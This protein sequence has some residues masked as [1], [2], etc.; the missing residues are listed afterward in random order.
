VAGQRDDFPAAIRNALAARASFRC[1]MC[2]QPTVGPSDESPTATSSI[3]TAAHI[4]AA[5]PG[6]RRYDETMT[7]E[8]RAGIG[9]GIWLCASHGRLVDT[10]DVTYTA[11]VLHRFKAGHEARCKQALGF[12]VG[13]G[14]SGGHLVALGPEIV[15]IGDIDRVEGARWRIGIDHFVVGDFSALVRFSDR[16]ATA[17]AYDRYVLVNSL[18]EGREID[19]SLTVHRDAGRVLV[20]CAVAPSFP[21]TN[22]AGLPKDYSL[23]AK[24]DLTVE[25]GDIA[26][27]SGL[28]ALP[29]KLLTCLSMRRGESPF[30]PEFGSRLS[31]YFANFIG[32][33][34]LDQLLKLDVVRLASIPYFDPVINQA[35]TPLMCVER[36]DSVVAIGEPT[37]RRLPVHLDLQIAG[38]GPWSRDLAVFIA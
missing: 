17:P 1:S 36:V 5:S 9:N 12:I 25:N 21:R 18:G 34:W 26:T 16:L 10:D 37:E 27:V 19:G 29:Q 13:A 32:S 15:C 31:D 20:E 28:A 33:P 24:H 6:G 8:A 22:A 38:L 23:S 4:C 7:P 30:H 11:E 2:D 35:Y 3:G 14:R